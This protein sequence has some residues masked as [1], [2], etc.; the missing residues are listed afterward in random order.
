VGDEGRRISN[1]MFHQQGFISVFAFRARW[2]T[3]LWLCVV[4]PCSVGVPKK[5][6][7]AVI[8]IYPLHVSSLFPLF[9][10]AKQVHT[11]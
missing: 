4:V 1:H 5:C 9:D 2:V 6:D 11:G 3:I 7:F 8:F 10:F